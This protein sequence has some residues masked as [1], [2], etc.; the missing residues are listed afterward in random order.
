VVRAALAARHPDLIFELSIISTKGDR[1]KD[2]PLPEIGGKGLFTE[3]LEEALRKGEVSL[4]VHSVKDLPVDLPDGF[5][6]GCI[7]T[8]EDP[9]D[10]LVSRDGLTLSSLPPAARVGTSS[11]RRK[12]Q[13]LHQRPDLEV[14]NLRGNVET[15]IRKVR[16]GVCDAAVLARAGIHRLGLD[17]EITEVID[18]DRILPPAGQGAVGIEILEGDEEAA[19]LAA[20]IENPLSRAEVIGEQACLRALGG[21]CRTP[22]GVLARVHTQEISIR[23]GVFSPDGREVYRAEGRGE[24]SRAQSLGEAIAADLLRQGADRLLEQEGDP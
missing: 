1:R 7:P 6:L 17:G 11:P 24:R 3:D 22:I 18:T 19:A 23:A 16:D 21:G 14:V 20:S 8:R 15:R 13:V 9:R 10:V 5:R 4:A 2:E 12:A